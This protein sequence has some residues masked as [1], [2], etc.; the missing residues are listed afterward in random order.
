M[1]KYLTL[2]KINLFILIILTGPSVSEHRDDVP[3]NKEKQCEQPITH[4]SSLT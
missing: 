4:Q 1:V 2:M 3:V